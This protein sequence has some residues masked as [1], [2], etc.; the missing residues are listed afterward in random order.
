MTRHLLPNEIDL[1][2][3]G[4]VGFGVAPLNAHVLE[5]ETCRAR[6]DELRAIVDQLD[7]LP[8][9]MPHTNFANNVM[10]QVQVIEPWNVAIAEN[11]RRLI[12][13]SMPMRLV[14]G[15][16]IVAAATLVSFGSLWLAVSTDLTTWAY[17]IFIDSGRETVV[18]GLGTLEVGPLLIAA[19]ALTATVVGTFLGFRKLLT[20]AQPKRS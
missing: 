9:F 11:A 3:D 15:V 5:C 1:L 2:V 20:G 13:S 17:R 10:A 8:H 6:V 18:A 7:A 16:G 12:P 14:A 19:T 4:D